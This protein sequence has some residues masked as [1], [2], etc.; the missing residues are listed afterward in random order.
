MPAFVSTRTI[1]FG[2][3]AIAIVAGLYFASSFLKSALDDYI[4]TAADNGKLE[5]ATAVN[6]ASIDNLIGQYN[7]LTEDLKK[8]QMK[9]D[10]LQTD[11]AANRRELAAANAKLK[12]LDI[13][14]QA[15]ANPTALGDRLTVDTNG[16]I[17]LLNQAGKLGTVYDPGRNGQGPNPASPAPAGL[18]PSGNAGKVGRPYSRRNRERHTRTGP[19]ARQP[20]RAVLRKKPVKEL[21]STRYF[22]GAI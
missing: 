14:G 17:E 21:R 15:N 11:Y 20:S 8:A 2:L 13:R 18:V 22:G 4:K 7:R 12:A 1:L 16:T 3:A 5:A 19:R 10:Q 9:I 6:K